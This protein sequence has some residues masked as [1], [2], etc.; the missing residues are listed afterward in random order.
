MSAPDTSRALSWFDI[1]NAIAAAALTL[2]SIALAF[3]L[4]SALG[5]IYYQ[6]QVFALREPRHRNPLKLNL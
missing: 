1:C 4:G 5:I 3:D 6:E 2:L